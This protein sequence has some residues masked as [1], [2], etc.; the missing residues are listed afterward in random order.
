MSVKRMLENEKKSL[1]D[2]K[3]STYFFD[4]SDNSERRDVRLLLAI[5]FGK[6]NSFYLIANVWGSG[7]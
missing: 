4:I 2:P 7:C 5:A 1:T 6:N 3:S